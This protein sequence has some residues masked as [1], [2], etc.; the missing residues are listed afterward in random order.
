MESEHTKVLSVKYEKKAHK[1]FKV[2]SYKN[3]GVIENV[4]REVHIFR[5]GNSPMMDWD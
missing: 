1:D 5:L 4:G 2:K 3:F